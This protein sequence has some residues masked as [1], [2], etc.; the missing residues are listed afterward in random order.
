MNNLVNDIKYLVSKK[1]K[2]KVDLDEDDDC[3][4]INFS[5][6]T[7]TFYKKLIEL[8]AHRNIKFVEHSFDTCDY[9]IIIFFSI[10]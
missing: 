3:L 10:Q 1:N 2:T 6:K 5:S 7:S 4:K 8:L 9:I